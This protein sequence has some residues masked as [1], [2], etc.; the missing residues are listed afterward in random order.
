VIEVALFAQ[1][2]NTFKIRGK[3]MISE[4]QVW[5]YRL[6]AGCLILGAAALHLAY[7]TI[8]CPLDLAPDEAHYWDWSR[9]LDWSYYSKGP[10]VAYLIRIS[11]ALTGRWFDSLS[12]TE[13]P[14]VR[15]PAVVCGSLLLVSLYVLTT[16]VYRREGLALSVVALALTIPIFAAGSSLMTIDAPYTCC[17][18]LAL[19]LGHQAVFRASAW[20]WPATGLLVGAGILAKYTMV[21][22]LLSFGLFLVTSPNRRALLA[23]PGFWIMATTATICTLPILWWNV[24][25]DWVSL[26]HVAG[27]AGLGPH[28]GIRWLGPLTYVGTQF[29]LLLGFWFVA[30]LIAIVVHRPRVELDSGVN[31]LWWMSAPAFLVFLLFSLVTSEEPN[32]PV[33][34][35]LSGFVLAIAWIDGRLAVPQLQTRFWTGVSL[36]AACALGLGLTLV[37]HHSEWI[38]PALARLSGPATVERPLPCRRFDPTCRLRGWRT[39]AAEVDRIRGVLRTEGVESVVSASGWTIPGELAFYCQ[40]HPTVYSLG[41]ALGDRHSQY[42]LWHPNPIA[43]PGQFQGRTFIFVGEVSSRVRDGFAVVDPPEVV[44]Q[45]QSGQPIAQWTLTV[46]RDFRGWGCPDAESDHAS[47]RQW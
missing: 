14:A 27:Q 34:A 31:Y 5:R 29:G 18:G 2:L 21:L 44:T 7:L 41:R 13:M 30:W 1:C 15:L 33:S 46:C 35:Y 17:W 32:W 42:D 11:T 47:R 20:A 19:V 37:I 22:W 43:D 24:N 8:E 10:V 23:R 3:A 38:Q 6:L 25:H 12:G 26:R 45:M 28:S 40:G 39:L 9:N 16:Q 4:R 36:G